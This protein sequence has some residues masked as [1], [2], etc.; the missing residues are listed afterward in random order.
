M[1]SA[2]IRKRQRKDGV[3]YVASVN[4]GK[5]PLSGKRR[6]R[7]ETFRTKRE[8]KAALARWETEIDKGTFVDRSSQTVGDLLRYWMDTEV[9]HNPR[10]A[11]ILRYRNTVD[12]HLIPGL[13]AVPLQKL[14]PAQVQR[15]YADKLAGGA[16]QRSVVFC[17]QRLHQALDMALRLGLVAR[18]VCD[19]VAPPKYERAQ[20]DMEPRRTGPLP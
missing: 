8:A 2:Y 16:G 1:A 11:T 18:N 20:G 7:S 3:V 15:F 17:H 13:G 5:D 4:L 12:K 14:T 10:E 9:I 19:A 6:E